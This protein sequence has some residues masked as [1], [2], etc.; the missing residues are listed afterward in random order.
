[1][2]GRNYDAEEFAIKRFMSDIFCIKSASICID[3][4]KFKIYN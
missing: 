1:M 3:V 4:Y 2:K